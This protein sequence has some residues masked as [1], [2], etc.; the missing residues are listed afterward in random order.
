MSEQNL[1]WSEQDK[2]N[3]RRFLASNPKFLNLLKKD[4]PKVESKGFEAAALE[5]HRKQGFED[6]IDRIESMAESDTAQ[7]DTK[8][9][10]P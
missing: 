7:D 2:V 3:L 4:R 5:G 9:I 1:E 8:F 10:T 6:A